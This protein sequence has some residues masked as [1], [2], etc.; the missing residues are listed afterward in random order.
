[1]QAA[2]VPSS[3]TAIAAGSKH[4]CAL[5]AGEVWCWGDNTFG[6]LGLGTSGATTGGPTPHRVPDLSGILLIAAGGS[7]SCAA[8]ASQT[9]CWGRGDS[10]QLGDGST[11]AAPQPTPKAV[12]G[13]A[14]AIGLA[15]GDAHTCAFNTSGVFCW[16]A[17]SAGQLGTGSATNPIASP[18]ASAI[19]D[20]VS[21]LGLGANHTCAGRSGSLMCWGANSAKQIDTSG[22]DQPS[23]K[24]VLSGATAVAGGIGHTCAIT[25]KQTVRCWGLND[26]GQLGG[27]IASGG[28]VDVNLPGVQKIAAGFEHT[29]AIQ[30]GAAFCWGLN[31]RG[32]LGANP[33]AAASSA[34]PVA[35]SGR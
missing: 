14:G 28:S 5:A 30:S 1:V 19:L 24:G 13:F 21:F 25:D 3:V 32:Q 6:Q 7:H 29:C 23:P 31:D 22:R 20:N 18:P 27:L 2:G 8:D 4:T 26:Q 10:G 16:G 11:S 17:N 9:Y 35:V 12:P 15:A 34:A 33:G